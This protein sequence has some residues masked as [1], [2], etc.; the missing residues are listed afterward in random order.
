[1]AHVFAR[2]CENILESPNQNLDFIFDLNVLFNAYFDLY[3]S[4]YIIHLYNLSIYEIYINL[5]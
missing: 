1:M 3:Y 5:F 4:I 2:V